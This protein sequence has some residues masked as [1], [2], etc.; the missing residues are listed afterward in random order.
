MS[1]TV[2]AAH[3]IARDCPWAETGDPV[4]VDKAAEKH[5]TRPP[6]HP[7]ATVTRPA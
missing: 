6:K 1:S 7:T 4:A 5:T 3:C 2:T